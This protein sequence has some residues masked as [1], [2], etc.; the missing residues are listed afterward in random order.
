[1]HGRRE[2]E[3]RTC[4]GKERTINK[5]GLITSNILEKLL[6][7][8]IPNNGRTTKDNVGYECP[9]LADIPSTSFFLH[10]RLE[11]RLALN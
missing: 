5:M 9:L 3:K 1:M 11:I 8:I 6:G 7:L 4:I 10:T 2:R